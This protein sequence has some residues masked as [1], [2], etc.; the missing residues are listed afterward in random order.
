M[1]LSHERLPPAH[2]ASH[3]DTCITF[4]PKQVPDYHITSTFFASSCQ[5]RR[6]LAS[7]VAKP[8]VFGNGRFYDDDTGSAI[9]FFKHRHGR[10]LHITVKL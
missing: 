4:A 1:F 8:Y 5:K 3:M 6:K 9:P 7:A 2:T 10:Q